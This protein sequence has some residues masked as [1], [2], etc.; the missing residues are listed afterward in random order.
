MA[1]DTWF[2]RRGAVAVTVG[3][4]LSP[5]G[6]GWAEAV[7]LRDAARAAILPHCG[8]PDAADHPR[9]SA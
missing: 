1:S 5:E 4:P 9:A 7:R 6:E 2:P 8:E 3:A